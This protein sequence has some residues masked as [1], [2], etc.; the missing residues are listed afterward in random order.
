MATYRFDHWERDG[1]S[2]G[3]TNPMTS[4]IITADTMFTAVFVLV[5]PVKRTV[6]IASTPT[7]IP[8]TS[9]AGTTPFQVLV[10]DGTSITLQAPMQVVG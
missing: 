5:S 8:I 7:G 9:P 10:D 1:V 6:T 3:T 4:P 2:I